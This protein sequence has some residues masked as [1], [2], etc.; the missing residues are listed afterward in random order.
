MDV[1][2]KEFIL[3]L[4]EK[5]NYTKKS[6]TTLVED[7]IDLVIDNLEEGNSVSFYGFGCFDMRWRAARSCPDPNTGERCD[8]PAHWV[9]KFHPGKRLRRAVSLMDAKERRGL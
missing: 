6:A 4:V 3:Q 5:H 2:R 9:P 7:F 1:N 8:I